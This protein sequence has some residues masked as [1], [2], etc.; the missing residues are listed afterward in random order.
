MA[1]E[2]NKKLVIS[3]EN[4]IKTFYL[5]QKEIG[6]LSGVDLKVFEGDFVVI[7]G[8][9]GCSKSTLLNILEGLEA[10][11]SGEC[12][13]NGKNIYALE[14]DERAKFRGKTFGII[15][16]RSYWVQSLNVLENVALPL[17]TNGADEKQSL[18]NAAEILESLKCGELSYQKPGQLS[19]G[20]QQKASCARALVSDPEIL[21]ADEPTGNLDSTSADAL[22]GI[23]ESLNRGWKKTV[24]MVTHNPA[25]R[26]VGN[27]QIEMRDGKIIKEENQSWA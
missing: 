7:F 10:P 3:V 12:Y 16:Q 14:D 15:H 26:E 19:G 1:N 21:I 6:A 20:E 23:I 22:V 27:R 4:L 11:T 18:Q 13:I 9:S 8:P 25:Y 2:K 5:G 24:V 17:I